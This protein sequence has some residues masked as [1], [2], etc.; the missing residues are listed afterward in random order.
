[1][2]RSQ[3][4]DKNDES[5]FFVRFSGSSGGIFLDCSIHDIDLARWL[6][7]NPKPKRVWATGT[8]AL[9]PAL[10]EHHRALLGIIAPG[11]PLPERVGLRAPQDLVEVH[12]VFR[13]TLRAALRGWVPR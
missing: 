4:C 9:H 5:G 13:E 1:M 7:G 11:G 3:T 10:A 12:G 8:N 6:L 2:V